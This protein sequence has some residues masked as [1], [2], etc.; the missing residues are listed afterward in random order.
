MLG[1]VGGW[2]LAAQAGVAGGVAGGGDRGGGWQG[3]LAGT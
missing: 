3:Q 2:R 1:G